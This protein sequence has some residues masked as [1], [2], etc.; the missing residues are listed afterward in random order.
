MSR[1]VIAGTDTGIGK[2]VFAAALTGAIGATYWKPVQSGLDEGTDTASVADLSGAAPDRLLPEAYRLVTPCSP[3]RA[4]EI[5]S[6]TIDPARLKPP[7]A[8]P[9]V[10]ELAGGLMVPLTRELLTI[11]LVASWGLP[12]ILVARTALGTINHS[13]L[14]IE[15]MRA[16]GIAMHGI[17]FVGGAVP[18]SE[19]TIAAMGRVRRLG[20]L[21][22]VEPLTHDTLAAAFARGF[23][24]ADFA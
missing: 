13:L 10:I 15:A 2:T 22:V 3:H 12:V 7:P 19:E 14:S 18:D 11:D 24:R 20:R 21:D 16:R 9:L 23:D 8:D 17:A 6:V 1:F 5:D 4:A